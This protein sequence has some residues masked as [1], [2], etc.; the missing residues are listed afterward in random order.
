MGKS[1]VGAQLNPSSSGPSFCVFHR[2]YSKVSNQSQKFSDIASKLPKS[3][4]AQGAKAAS[5]LSK[6]FQISKDG[7]LVKNE[8]SLNIRASELLDFLVTTRK[9]SLT[10]E[11]VK[12]I[13]KDISDLN[14][15][16]R[17]NARKVI[18][19]ATATS[20]KVNVK[21]VAVETEK[22]SVQKNLEEIKNIESTKINSSDKMKTPMENLDILKLETKINSK[23]KDAVKGDQIKPFVEAREQSKTNLTKV[24]TNQS[25]K[26]ERELKDITEKPDDSK[27]QISL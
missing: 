10:A 13:A 20:E 17:T 26:L 1:L 21:E 16:I 15:N 18:D 6:M 9:T 3:S 25:Q 19:E 7:F 14:I 12:D 8:K 23:P 27:T 4:A 11:T 22:L 5:E 24:K 2:R